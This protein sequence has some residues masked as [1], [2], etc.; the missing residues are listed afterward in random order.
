MWI[1][2]L[3]YFI[4]IV[5]LLCS[6]CVTQTDWED[7]L[8]FQRDCFAALEDLISHV[9]SLLPHKLVFLTHFLT[10]LTANL[11]SDYQQCSPA[12]FE[13]TSYLTQHT[14]VTWHHFTQTPTGHE[15]SHH[16]LTHQCLLGKVHCGL[17]NGLRVSEMKVKISCPLILCSSWLNVSSMNI[18]NYC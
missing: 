17:D 9:F 8:D 15:R 3:K 14:L 5:E 11:Y 4:C 2:L 6:I 16:L 18:H 12:T 13:A 7:L 10:C 1:C